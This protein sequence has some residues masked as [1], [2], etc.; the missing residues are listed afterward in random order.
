MQK[1][2][3]IFVIKVLYA[4]LTR[5]TEAKQDPFCKIELDTQK[6]QTT[7]KENT[8]TKPIWE[9]TF[10]L[11]KLEKLTKL[12]VSIWDWDSPTK[13]DLIGEGEYD[14]K[15]L[16]LEEKKNISI[17][18]FFKSKKAGTVFMDVCYT[19]EKPPEPKITKK[20][21]FSDK[22]IENYHEDYKKIINN[23]QKIDLDNFLLENKVRTALHDGLILMGQTKPKNPINFLGNFLLNYQENK[24]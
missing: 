17:E 20:K 12:K 5:I 10:T 19:T 6:F 7:V 14:L 16:K 24:L 23:F 22:F 13:S 4:N 3:E 15:P 2:R 18:I 1:Y 9:E 21:L 11:I 8:P